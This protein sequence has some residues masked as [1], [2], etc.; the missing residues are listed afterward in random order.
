MSR[1]D[2]L[3]CKRYEP[4]ND[5]GNAETRVPEAETGSGFGFCVVLAAHENK[6]GRDG[7]FEYA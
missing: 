2:V 5:L 6:G 1:S 3:E 4:A 7:G